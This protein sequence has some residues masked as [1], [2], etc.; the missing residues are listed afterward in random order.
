MLWAIIRR[1]VALV[2]GRQIRKRPNDAGAVRT[3]GLFW[4]RGDAEAGDHRR[5]LKAFRAM[6]WGGE[7]KYGRF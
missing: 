7:L 5:T 4:M 3:T 2:L 1:F 6:H